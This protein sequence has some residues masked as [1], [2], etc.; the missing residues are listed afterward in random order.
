MA[1]A[2][3]SAT[4]WLRRASVQRRWHRQDGNPYPLLGP[5]EPSQAPVFLRA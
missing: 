5:Y 3:V 4:V 2:V 1:G